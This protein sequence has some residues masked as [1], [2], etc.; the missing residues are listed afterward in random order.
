MSADFAGQPAAWSR[1]RLT[2]LWQAAGL[3]P[4]QV[5]TALRVWLDG[6]HRS[7]RPL[8]EVLA[9]LS[10][11]ARGALAPLL[12]PERPLK[13]LQD[14]AAADGTR[15]LLWQTTDGQVIES[16]IIVASDADRTTLCVSSQVGC[17]RRCAFC[18]TGRLGLARNLDAGEIVAQFQGASQLWAQVRGALPPIRNVVFMGMG[19]PLDNLDEVAAATSLLG[20][21]LAYG[22]SWRHITVST[23]GVAW[24]LPAFF[25]Q[26]RA[27]L[28]VSLNAPDDARRQ[29]IMPVNERCDMAAL[30]QALQKHL[31]KGRDVLVEY[32]LFGGQNDALEDAVLLRQWL[33]G[34]P[35]RLNLIPANPGP[36]PAL[37][38]P[39]P[40]AVWRFHKYLL[41]HG[42]RAMVRHPHGRELGGA[43]G[44]LAGPLR[45]ALRSGQ[46]VPSRPLARRAAGLVALAAA[47]LLGSAPAP[48]RAQ[49]APVPAPVPAPAPV[50]VPVP[51]PAQAQ[52]LAAEPAPA[53]FVR[54]AA[55]G[56][57]AAL[58]TAVVTL[59]RGKVQLEVVGAVHVADA[60]YYA[61]LNQLFAKQDAVFYELVKPADMDMRY[62]GPDDGSVSAL[63]RL[64]KDQLHLTFQL[65]AIGYN[66]RNFVHADMA[67]EAL[68]GR[69]RQEVPGI[70]Q[71]LLLWSV[72]DAARTRYQDGTPRLPAWELAKALLDPD[73][74]RGLKRLLGRELAELDGSLFELGQAGKILIAE[75]NQIAVDVVERNLQRNKRLRRVAVFYGA[76]HL[77]DLL[78]R[79]QARGF[80]VQGQRWLCAWD[81]R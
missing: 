16:V 69:L 24:R 59:R 11:Q 78:Q 55:S 31:P 23:V 61:G 32:V 47:V 52:V 29:R 10:Q 77:P 72:R 43:C 17:G 75:R 46:P 48:T 50:P 39:E 33:D 74:A 44:Q 57:E 6:L 53:S 27:H 28:A 18:E 3:R 15:K 81:L 58:S 20:D 73:R 41:D 21:T 68:G 67:S 54:F 13:L 76:A 80:A 7:P 34:L 12:H 37:V 65:D 63:Q 14:E 22:L 19:E 79:L 35:V 42:V 5:Q 38:A 4:G 30:K 25:A 45:A 26:V 36:D 8:A 62:A 49:P 40:E 56:P 64:I 9:Q 66:R 71:S 1:E 51:A 60:G 70:L 2:A